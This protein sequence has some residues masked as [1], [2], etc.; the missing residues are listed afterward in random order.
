MVTKSIER[1]QERLEENNF[2]TRKRLLDYDDV[3]N[4]QREVI[5][6]RRRNA[7]S[8][9]RLSV[10]IYNMLT[11]FAQELFLTHK[12]N[13]DY[14]HFEQNCLLFL[15]IEPN[16]SEAEFNA[17]SDLNLAVQ[18]EEQAAEFY[19]KKMSTIRKT[20]LPTI[21]N[22]FETEGERYKNIAIPF[23]DGKKGLNLVVNL[24]EAVGSDGG[25]IVT[26]LEKGITLALIDD[27][28]KE[29]LR[30][31]DEL[32][33]ASFAAQFEQKDPL[34]VYKKEA[35]DLFKEFVSDVNREVTNFLLKGTIQLASPD[36]VKEARAPRRAVS[37]K[38]K[39][40]RTDE[41][42][43]GIPEGASGGGEAARKVETMKREQPKVGRNEP[44]PCGSGK[45]FK[46]CHGK[47]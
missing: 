9:E 39:T 38:T 23:T 10:D 21:K 36:D 47:K 18:F 37:N 12:H 14:E 30:S 3:M 33:D 6:K 29:H 25:A 16:F 11:E 20:V 2:G 28:W 44:C 27:N 19:A 31:M 13:S 34:V 46:Q 43:Q 7:L 24:E 1:A 8:G 5:Y 42:P 4:I 40:N 15:G 45:K 35:Y 26:E 41:Q 32:K 22:V 17:G